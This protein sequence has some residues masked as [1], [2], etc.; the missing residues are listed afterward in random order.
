M[1]EKLKSGLTSLTYGLY[2]VTVDNGET[3]SAMVAS[4]VSQVSFNPP[5]IMV[6]IKKERFIHKIISELGERGT[7]HFGLMVVQKNSCLVKMLLFVFGGGTIL[8]V[9]LGL[10]IP[11][12]TKM[13]KHFSLH[14]LHMVEFT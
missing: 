11:V 8:L 12:Q 9:S 13:V 10:Y 3:K 7:V 14:H 5:R 1:D 6:T 4:W 2:I